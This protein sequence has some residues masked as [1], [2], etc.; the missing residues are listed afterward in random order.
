MNSTSLA[1][2]INTFAPPR[3]AAAP[4]RPS[5]ASAV[6]AAARNRLRACAYASVRELPCDYNEGILVLRGQVSSY[7][8]KQVAQEAVRGLPGVEVIVNAVVVVIAD[9]A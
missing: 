1:D 3:V 4:R 7:F 9:R 5:P 2:S 6:A 8:H